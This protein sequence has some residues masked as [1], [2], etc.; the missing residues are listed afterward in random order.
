MPEIAAAVLSPP[1]PPDPPRN[2]FA[3]ENIAPP[4]AEKAKPKPVVKA[5]PRVSEDPAKLLAGLSLTATWTRGASSLA[6]I[7]GRLYA[8]G[9]VLETATNPK[10]STSQTTSKVAGTDETTLTKGGKSAPGGENAAEPLVVSQILPDK[11]L[12]T[13]GDVTL[14]LTFTGKEDGRR[15]A[16]P[17][18]SATSKAEA[19]AG[20]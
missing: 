2:L 10:G 1:A 3:L 14:E 17:A 16:A 19:K 18:R 4:P 9:D 6:M 11:V 8:T 13:R 15:G 20:K 12:L 5:R 7:N